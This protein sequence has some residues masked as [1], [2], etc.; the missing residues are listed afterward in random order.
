MHASS[1]DCGGRCS[2]LRVYAL[3]WLSS[4]MSMELS[5]KL[6]WIL[7]LVMGMG[8]NGNENDHGNGVEFES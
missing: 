4:G 5:V 3:S 2:E 7:S 8:W 1:A 6:E